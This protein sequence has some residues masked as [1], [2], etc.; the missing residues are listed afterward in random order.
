VPEQVKEKLKKNIP[1]GRLGRIRDIETTAVFLCS[2]A[3]SFINGEIV[4]VDGGQWL[5]GRMW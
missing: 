3:A 5:S 4:V 2:D 1:V